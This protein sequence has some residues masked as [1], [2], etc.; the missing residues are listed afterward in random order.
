M[1]SAGVASSSGWDTR[2]A[3]VDLSPTLPD[4][5]VEVQHN[6]TQ[7]IVRVHAGTQHRAESDANDLLVGGGQG[8]GVRLLVARGHEAL[9]LIGH[10][11]RKVLQVLDLEG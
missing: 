5:F 4:R 10:R 3:A 9:V 11:L 1:S 8:A 6:R 7:P 2:T